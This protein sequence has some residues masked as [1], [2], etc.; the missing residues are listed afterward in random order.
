MVPHMSK[1]A[2]WTWHEVIV[3]ALKNLEGFAHWSKIEA[4]ARR[5]APK[6]G[7]V[8]PKKFDALVRDSL[9]DS[10][11]EC[12]DYKH[13]GAIFSMHGNGYWSFRDQK[14]PIL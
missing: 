10:C 7:K 5:I 13:K 14:I 1:K 4:E 3:L 2:S 12:P 9:Q 6:Y 8:P 11:P